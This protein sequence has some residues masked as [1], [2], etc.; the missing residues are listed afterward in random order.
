V[1]GIV[2]IVLVSH[3]AAIAEG[4]AEL[5]AEMGGPE[6]TIVP[7]GGVEAPEPALG[8]DA[9]RVAAAIEQAD[10]GEGVLVLMDLGSAVLSAEMALELLPEARRGRVVLSAAPFVEGAVAAAVAARL[11]S[12]LEAVE[13]EARG[14]AAPK[15]AQLGDASPVPPAEPVVRAGAVTATLPVPNS[16]GLHA[17]P[18]VRFVQTAARFDADVTVENATTG[19][20][21]VSARSLNGLATLGARQGHE[22]LVA[23]RGP[24]AEG[25]LEALRELADDGFGDR[26]EQVPAVPPVEPRRIDGGALAGLPASPGIATG[27]ARHLRV[28]VVEVPAAPAGDPAVEWSALEGALESVR[29][30]L[31]ASR[32]SVAARAGEAAAEIFDAHLLF[33]DDDALLGPA[34]R[35]VFEGARNAAQAWHAAAERV[36]DEYRGLEDDY[37]RARADDVLAVAARVVAHLAGV[38]ERGPGLGG[39]G[40]VVAA[41]LTPAET[42]ALDRDLVRGLATARG[43]PTSHAAILARSLGIPAAVGLGD[44]LLAV[45]EGGQLLLDGG[46]GLLYVEPSS[47]VAAEYAAGA[48]E[49][50]AAARSAL[51]AASAPAVTRDGRRIAVL[52]NLGSADEAVAAVEVG[53]EGVGLLRTEFLYLDRTEPPGE[54]EQVRTYTAIA[55]AL[56]GRPLVVRTLDA[57]ADKPLPFLPRR[58]EENPFL[59]ERGIRLSLAEPALL[60]A[61][62]RAVLRVAARHDVKV[63]F[64]MVATI[65][66][67]REARSFLDEA[68][69]ELG[70]EA[71][72]VGAMVEVPAAA[73][74]ADALARE[75]DFLSIGTND[76]AQYTMA[77]ERGN[78][79]VAALTDAL[80]PPV[81][82]LIRDVAAAAAAHGI[83]VAV[84]GEVASDALAVPL[85]LG[86]GVGELSVSAPLVP[87]IKEAVRTVSESAAG[88][89][90][91][92]AL[93]AESAAAVRALLAETSATP[94]VVG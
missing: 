65:G 75:A 46:R 76:L 71:V 80:H 60:R 86:L 50:E 82:R 35:A 63:M 77:A 26:A 15:A 84:C 92:R 2:G 72:E 10:G 56:G 52:A 3:S 17:R 36:A 53:A 9:V 73:L 83:P 1:A 41:D 81:L 25:A 78:Q 40:I 79:R 62:L 13:A 31:R 23:A 12:S 44:A 55:E 87:A 74:A 69:V 51:A 22:L 68:S 16:L 4:V 42:A 37:Q 90:A 48:S 38:G 18:A 24:Q 34:R 88:A 8:T 14:G 5:A 54:D 7:A 11:G 85:L 29:V 94:T 19:R 70:A 91:E 20:G 64:P 43:G 93:E 28:P 33:L 58:P 67:F 32:E 66:E 6:V 39:P 27:V 57:G 45:P 89:L 21:P 61:Q 47:E 49:R 30:E 59:G